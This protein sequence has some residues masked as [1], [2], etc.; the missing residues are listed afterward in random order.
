MYLSRKLLILTVGVLLFGVL[1][2]Y[3]WPKPAPNNTSS[4]AQSSLS[5]NPEQE[6]VFIKDL[7]I[8]VD[9]TTQKS[10]ERTLY[11][12]IEKEA[13]ELYTGTLRKE[14]YHKSTSSANNQT[15]IDLVVD[16]E[17]VQLTYDITLVGYQGT[18]SVN[19]RCAPQEQQMVPS[20]ICRNWLGL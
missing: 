13:P 12:H 6:R 2:Y 17:P 4:E 11:L 20:N 9:P 7:H 14:S 3:F 18:Y 15:T 8:Y 16:V 1:V 19:I 5:V 10:V